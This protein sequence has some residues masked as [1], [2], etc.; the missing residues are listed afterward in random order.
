MPK[1]ASRV[2][3][4]LPLRCRVGPV[5]GLT[6]WPDLCPRMASAGEGSSQKKGG[7]GWF[8]NARVYLIPG[9]PA[10]MDHHQ[11]ALLQKAGTAPLGAFPPAVSATL[12]PRRDNPPPN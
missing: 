12:S 6:T 4:R 10:E 3:E 5:H 2:C 7:T 11:S 1:R 8:A 9:A